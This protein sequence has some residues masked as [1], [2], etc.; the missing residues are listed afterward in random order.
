MNHDDVVL[1]NPGQSHPLVATSGLENSEVGFWW[2]GGFNV[3]V[4]KGWQS[5]LTVEGNLLQWSQGT[6][7]PGPVLP[8]KGSGLPAS[9]QV[10]NLTC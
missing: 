10:Q 8:C 9:G 6:A 3:S 7:G 2:T 4:P 1:I 5:I